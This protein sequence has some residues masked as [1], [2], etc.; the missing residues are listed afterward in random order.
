MGIKD[1]LSGLTRAKGSDSSREQAK[2]EFARGN[3]A[4]GVAALL[5]LGDADPE[6]QFQLG[7]CYETATG[8][9]LNFATAAMW[10]ER[11]AAKGHLPAQAKLGD[12]Y[13]FGRRAHASPADE[14]KDT[15]TGSSRLRPKGVSVPQDF[16]KAL[17]WNAVAAE[18]GLADAQGRLAY[19]Y[20]MGHGVEP[21]FAAAER[22]FSAAAQQGGASGQFGLG[23]LYAGAYLGEVDYVKAAHWFEQAVA[24]HDDIPS[25]Y[26]LALLL[27]DGLGIPADQER[28]L[29][30]LGEA[31]EKQHTDAMF[32]LGE[33][34]QND[35]V[36]KKNF[37]LAET[38]L[39]RAGSRGHIKALVSLARL[40]VEGTVVPDYGSAAVVL[41]EAA[42][43]SDGLAQYYLGQFYNLGLGVHHDPTEAAAWFRKAADQ[44]II[45]AIESLGVMHATGIGQERDLQA[46]FSL[47]SLAAEKGSASADFNIGNL[48]NSG[49]GERDVDAAI[50][51]YRRA[52][53]RGSAEACVSL[54]VSYA[55]GD[56]VEQDYA[57]AAEWYA[58]AEQRGNTNGTTNLAFLYIRGLG[59]EQ[60]QDRGIR[61]L[62]TLAEADN[63]AAVWSLYHLF[64]PGTYVPANLAAAKRWLERAADMGSGTAAREFARQVE[65]GIPG[66][67]PVERVLAWLTGAADKGDAAAQEVLGRWLY[68]G[69]FVPRNEAGALRWNSMAAEGGN[70]FAQAWIGDV[71]YQG[72]G[73][74]MDRAAARRWYEKAAE[75][76]HLGALIILT[77]IIG[78]ETPS[79]EELQQLFLLW[80]NIAKAGDETAQLR[81][82]DFYL[83]GI[84][85]ERSVPEAV[86]WLRSAA[87]RG[88]AVAQVQLGG[89]MLQADAD[90]VGGSPEEAVALFQQAATR[91]NVDGE[92]NLG[93]CYRRGIGVHKDRDRARHL[94]FGAAIK[95][96][97]S[98]QLALGDLLVEIGTS[99]ALKEAIKWYEEA[100]SAGLP[101]AFHGLA[102]L[103]ETGAGVYPNPEKAILLNRRAA[104]GGHTGAIAALERLIGA[105]QPVA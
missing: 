95:G 55:T 54:G 91:G 27:K 12:F 52:A 87:E 21:D 48:Y 36:G 18:A 30:L 76:R 13:L 23:M 4:A 60:N 62:E 92:Y 88:S 61:M 65:N 94:Y 79:V 49:L 41:R 97:S 56:G 33:S 8:V 53:E 50:A 40:L 5:Q 105:P 86:N 42:D 103:Y 34:Y 84:G 93:V 104:E 24:D 6:V 75:Q 11:A 1:I 47:L 57:A 31:A 20:A 7:E 43:L 39:R 102:N 85:V 38:W 25:K 2:R 45:G 14:T 80:L 29:E 35:V 89:L 71:L 51:S 82:V 70:P 46:A 44:G 17:H 66:A 3:N 22:W 9:I 74:I 100:S 28:A 58:V 19:Q 83:R 72:L 67:P 96:N 68:E 99:E 59:V 73:V 37:A 32:R 78:R 77:E 15:G 63:L 64:V 98:A 90:D 69:K 16:A 10:Y 81:V 101:G 26:Y